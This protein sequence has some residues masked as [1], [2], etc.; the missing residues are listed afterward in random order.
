MH[1]TLGAMRAFER[2]I[3]SRTLGF[4]RTNYHLARHHLARGEPR[5]AAD[6]LRPALQG[7]L[8]S[9]N[10]YVTHTEVHQLLAEAYARLGQPDS[11]LVHRRWI[12]AALA[13]ADSGAR[14]RLAAAP[15]APSR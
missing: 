5:R 3:Y 1:D 4:T 2:G 8:E 7:S 15:D 6:L 10:Y 9:S 12:A 11:A 13:Q 14:A